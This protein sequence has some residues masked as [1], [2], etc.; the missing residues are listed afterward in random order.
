MEKQNLGKKSRKKGRKKIKKADVSCHLCCKKRLPFFSPTERKSVGGREV[1]HNP[2]LLLIGRVIEPL[3]SV[4]LLDEGHF[5]S[6]QFKIEDVGILLDMDG[7]GRLGK[8]DVALLNVPTQNN[9]RVRLAIFGSKLAEQRFIQQVLVGMAKRKPALHHRAIGL[10]LPFEGVLL[11]I[12]V[13]LHLMGR[14][15]DGRRLQNLIERAVALKVAQ[16]DA[17]H[18]AG[19]H[20]PFHLLYRRPHSRHAPDAAA[21]GQYSQ[22]PGV[23]AYGLWQGASC[24]RHTMRPQLGSDPD[25]V[26]VDAALAHRLPHA[27]LVLIGMGGIDVPIADAQGLKT[28]HTGRLIAR[29]KVNSESELGN[30][31]NRRSV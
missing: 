20:R 23:A 28:G 18:L 17:A 22:C 29:H 14:R 13:T 24:P 25:V 2:R 9:L 31:A 21:G 19:R 27:T 1:L 12:G 7:V 3:V 30:D 8:H 15:Q 6:R 16:S 26:T 5:V 10:H 4:H 11:E